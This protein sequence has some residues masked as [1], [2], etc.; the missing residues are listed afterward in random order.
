MR[1]KIESG[2]SK[3][4]LFGVKLVLGAHFKFFAKGLEIHK[5]HGC[6][7]YLEHFKGLVWLSAVNWISEIFPEVG[8]LEILAFPFKNVNPAVKTLK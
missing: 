4:C 5:C 7:C 8:V 6:T 2:C 3:C 1:L